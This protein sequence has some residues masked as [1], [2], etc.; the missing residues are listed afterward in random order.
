MYLLD[1]VIKIDEERNETRSYL[2]ENGQINYVTTSFDKWNKQRVTMSG[3]LMT[4]GRVMYDDKLLESKDFQ[5]YQNRQS[6]LI[7]KGCTAVAVAPKI[8]YAREI[9]AVFKRAK[10][11]MASSTLDYVV[12]MTIPISL[13]RPAV[14]RVCQQ[15]RIPFVRVEIQSFQQLKAI[16][17]T[18]IS[19]TLLTY[20]TVLIPVIAPSSDRLEIALL[21][22]WMAYCSNF[23]I[24]TTDPLEV[25]TCWNKP[26]LQKMGLYPNKGTMLAGSD[27][28]YL[29]FRDER[30]DH[31]QSIDQKVARGDRIVYYEKEPDVVVLKGEIVKTYE[32][33]SLKPGYGR[34]ID[35]IRPGRFLSLQDV[36]AEAY[37][38]ENYL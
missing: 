24:H 30:K 21:K 34:L 37:Q 26:L 16:P 7:K 19:Q 18:H 15:F 14:L 20:P 2:I 6:L 33:I 4:N 5:D 1:K 13:L 35:V 23:Q 28:D 36:S 9:E 22:E 11:E 10:H 27:A 31:I 12:G 8:Q 3:I 29:L 38:Q 32:T 17:W 25:L